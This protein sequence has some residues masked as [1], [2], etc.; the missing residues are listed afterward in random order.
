[1]LKK[2]LVVSLLGMSSTVF[3]GGFQLKVG[4]SVIAPTD[5]QP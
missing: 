3:A 1:M 5:K 2:L 4:A